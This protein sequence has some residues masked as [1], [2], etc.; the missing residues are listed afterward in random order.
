M[1]VFVVVVVAFLIWLLAVVAVLSLCR[2]AKLADEHAERLW[3]SRQALK[4][5]CDLVMEGVV[6][7]DE[8]G[9]R[10]AEAA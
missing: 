8:L 3:L 2:A 1:S 7:D 5:V 6:D 9:S 10:V 4:P